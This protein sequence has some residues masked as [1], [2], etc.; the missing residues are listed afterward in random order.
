LAP[1][2]AA[3]LTL[4]FRLDQQVELDRKLERMPIHC[5]SISQNG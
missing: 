3:A 4:L 1:D 5:I 2:D